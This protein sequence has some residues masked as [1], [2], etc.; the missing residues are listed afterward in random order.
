MQ[1][2]RWPQTFIIEPDFINLKLTLKGNQY[3]E[4]FEKL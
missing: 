1:E 4:E 3:V 2:S